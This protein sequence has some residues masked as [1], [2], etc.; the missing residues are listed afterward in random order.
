MVNYAAFAPRNP[1]AVDVTQFARGREDRAV[2]DDQKRKQSLQR[3]L[4]ENGP[5]LAA[6]DRSA[7]DGLS[8]FDPEAA[9][10]LSAG[11]SKRVATDQATKLA[12][13]KAFGAALQNIQDGD[14][15][16]Y[17]ALE[18]VAVENGMITQEQAAQWDVSRLP[19]LRAMALDFDQKLDLRK[20]DLDEAKFNQDVQEWTTKLNAPAKPADEYGRYVQEELAEGREPLSRI[21]YAQAKKGKGTTISYDENGRPVVS[22][23]GAASADGSTPKLNE[24]EAKGLIY[25]ERANAA[26][27]ILNEHEKQLTSLAQTAR[28]KVPIAGNYL[29][30]EEYQQA[31]QAGSEFLASILRKDTGAA[32]TQQEF[33]LYGPMFLPMP[34]DEAAVLAQKKESRKI[35]VDAIKK[36]LGKG[37]AVADPRTGGAEEPQS[38]APERTRSI[39][40]QEYVLRNGKWM[41]RR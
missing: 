22:I 4:G 16:G 9:Q 20:A 38:G 10:R 30:S 23:G 8:R 12:Q 27:A 11:A 15:D 13:A 39:G 24:T 6:G 1:I 2:M 35:A 17:N 3:F 18:R 41:R 14:A 36:T 28:S 29:V 40:G 21:D 26:E 19:A 5:A 31:Q 32:I 25:Y 37:N 7:V 34:G 33:D